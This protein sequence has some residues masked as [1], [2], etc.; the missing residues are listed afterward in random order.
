MLEEELKKQDEMWELQIQLMEEPTLKLKQIYYMRTWLINLHS[1]SK[2][3][4]ATSTST[5]LQ[6]LCSGLK[7]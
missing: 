4:K 5:D 3:F 6:H 7:N 1:L 2:E